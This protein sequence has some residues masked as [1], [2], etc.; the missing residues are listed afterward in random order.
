MVV[1]ASLLAVLARWAKARRVQSL[2]GGCGPRQAEAEPG[3]A[4]GT[5]KA[6]L[7]TVFQEA[8]VPRQA[9]L[10]A[11]MPRNTTVPK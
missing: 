1:P 9:E 2:A 11:R 10:V 8:G 6:G 3:R 4:Y 5:A 7:K